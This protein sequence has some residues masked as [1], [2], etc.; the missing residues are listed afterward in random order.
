M[1]RFEGQSAIVTG[2]AGSI[3]AATARRLNRLLQER[4]DQS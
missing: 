3:G 4:A 1:Q 2:A